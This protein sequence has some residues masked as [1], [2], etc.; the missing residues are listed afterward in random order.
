MTVEVVIDVIY[1]KH[2]RVEV[3][4][5]KG[6]E[7]ADILEQAVRDEI[8]ALPEEIGNGFW[9]GWDSWEEV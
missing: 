1:T 7:D 3:P 2:I 9:Y 8:E 4:D 5:I 6:T